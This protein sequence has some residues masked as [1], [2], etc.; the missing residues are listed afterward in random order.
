MRKL[1]SAVLLAS[2]VISGCEKTNNEECTYVVN[3]ATSVA[4]WKGSAPDHFHVGSFEVQGSV[5]TTEDGTIKDGKFIIPI[6]SIQDFDLT[7]AAVREQLLGHL[8]SADFFNMALYPN[9]EFEITKIEAYSGQDGITGANKL[10]TGNFT[11]TGQTHPIS[12]PASINYVGDSL[13]VA[14]TF[15]IDRTKWGMTKYNDPEDAEY[16]LPNADITLNIQAAKQ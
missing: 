5:T 1:L 12:F 16:L 14:S 3:N 11:M 7:D 4:E 8:K 9:A 2:I 13:K 6:A 15:K 10:V